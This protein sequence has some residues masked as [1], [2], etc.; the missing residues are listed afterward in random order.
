MKR[1]DVAEQAALFLQNHD[2]LSDAVTEKAILIIHIQ[3]LYDLLRI[4]KD[5]ET[6]RAVSIHSITFMLVKLEQEKW[7]ITSN[8]KSEHWI[9]SNAR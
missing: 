3:M 1:Y 4:T 9:N 7:C 5:Q 6:N 8:M 2:R